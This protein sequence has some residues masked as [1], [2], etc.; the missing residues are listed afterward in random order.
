MTKGVYERRS[1]YAISDKINETAAVGMSPKAWPA[2]PVLDDS[3]APW[4]PR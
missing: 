4:F 3:L 2:K 1:T